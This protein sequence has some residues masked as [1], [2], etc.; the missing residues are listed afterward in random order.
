MRKCRDC[1]FY[2]KGCAF[3]KFGDFVACAQF[4]PKSDK[5]TESK[6]D[7]RNL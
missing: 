4:Q 6:K 1:K 7:N 5:E 3:D 2:K